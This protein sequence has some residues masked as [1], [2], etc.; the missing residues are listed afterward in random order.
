MVCCSLVTCLMEVWCTVCVRSLLPACSMH[1]PACHLS[2]RT[3]NDL[4]YIAHKERFDYV[5]EQHRP[6]DVWNVTGG[7]ELRLMRGV[8]GESTTALNM[9][10]ELAHCPLFTAIPGNHDIGLGPPCKAAAID[11]FRAAFGALNYDFSIANFT[12]VVRTKLGQG[13]TMR[14]FC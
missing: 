7:V 9:C 13:M 5:F 2:G 3:L 10:G 14:L 6:M 8:C 11:R 4:Q 12:F 1:S